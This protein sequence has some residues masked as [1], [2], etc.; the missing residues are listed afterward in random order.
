MLTILNRD[1]K[2]VQLFILVIISNVSFAQFNSIHINGNDYFIN[3][4]NLPWNNFGWDFGIHDEWGAGYDNLF[5]ESAFEEF[6]NNGVNCIRIWV[7]CDGRANP[8][9]DE[10]GYVTGLD[11]G[12]LEQLEDF[13]ERA[14][15]HSL[16]VII[17]LWSH[18]MFEDHTDVA[19]SFGGLHSDLI[20]N[21]DKTDSY[22]VNAL[23]PIVRHLK[24]YCNILAWEIMNEPEWGMEINGGGSTH[25]TVSAEAMQL[26][27]GKCIKAIRENS[28]HYITIGAA[29]PFGNS[30]DDCKNYW[31][32]KEFENLGF[33][34]EE[35]YLDFYSFHYYDWM[36]ANQSPFTKNAD[37]WE[38]G[39]PILIAETASSSAE[40]PDSK[41]PSE[42]INACYDYGYSGIMFWSYNAQDE[43]SDWT[44]CYTALNSFAADQNQLVN[45]QNS[46]DTLIPFKPILSCNIYPNPAIDYVNLSL[47]NFTSSMTASIKITDIKGRILLE[48]ENLNFDE[49]FYVGHFVSGLYYIHLFY[50][51]G[52]GAYIPVN[53]SKLVITTN[54]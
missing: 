13:I 49:S 1:M 27:M 43:F 18:D 6:E 39:K 44:N 30:V 25:Q 20:T 35:V 47:H 33:N 24:D 28:N 15:D 22:I 46:C 23:I 12:L 32:E 16:M 21:P 10:S 4:I 40:L 51:E 5:F 3:G 34:C 38:L 29:F 45:Y 36:K 53:A 17:T 42:Q 52:S 37:E 2:F 19:G 9:F 8:E 11:E 54:Q 50:K 26:F 14:N 48:E 31:H 41:T 7:H